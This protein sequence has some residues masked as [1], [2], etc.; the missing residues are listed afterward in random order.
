MKGTDHTTQQCSIAI[1]TEHALTGDALILC[2]TDASHLSMHVEADT[3]IE[4]DSPLQA[5]AD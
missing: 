3:V 1:A 4:V 2:V 5:D